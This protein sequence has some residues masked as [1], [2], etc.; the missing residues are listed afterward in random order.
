MITEPKSIRINLPIKINESVEN[1]IEFI[2]SRNKSLTEYTIKNEIKEL[3]F[4]YG[5]EHIK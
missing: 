3:L 2:V 1:A 4:K 5:H